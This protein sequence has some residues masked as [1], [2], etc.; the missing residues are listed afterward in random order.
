MF[1]YLKY[2][3][4]EIF[5]LFFDHVELVLLSLFIAL[6]ISIPL[7]Y[8]LYSHKTLSSP[9]ITLLSIIY[10]IP[11]IAFFAVLIPLTGIGKL[12]A[13]IALVA[14]SLLIIT[15]NII[16]G[17]Q[18]INHSVIHSA[19]GM[20]FNSAQILYKIQLPLALP[21]IIAGIRIASV[22]IISIA[23]IAAWINAGGLGVILFDGLY[24]NYAPKIIT[25]T[26]LI[27]SLA[28]FIN[29]FLFSLE[30]MALQRAK[31]EV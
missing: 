31:G 16:T 7:G 29:S 28:M 19:K 8:L 12:T 26:V 13:I 3:F 30:K 15:R 14:Y 27:A 1:E 2:N 4:Y 20:G 5:C 24:Q 22:S 23:T 11:S 18:G 25:G 21:S 9:V 17:F 10:T 6:I